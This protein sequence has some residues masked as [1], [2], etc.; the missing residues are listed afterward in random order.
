MHNVLFFLPLQV[1]AGRRR[2]EEALQAP[3]GAAEGPAETQPHARG[4]RR[5]HGRGHPVSSLLGLPGAPGP[6]GF[7]SEEPPAP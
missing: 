7:S 3:P 6:E 2:E 4:V 5:Q 1:V